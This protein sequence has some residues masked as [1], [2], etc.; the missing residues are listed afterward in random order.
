MTTP[1]NTPGYEAPIGPNDPANMAHTGNE[2][3]AQHPFH[4]GDHHVGH[5]ERP[6]H[7]HE[8]HGHVIVSWQVLTGVLGLLLFFTVLTVATAGI[9][10]W[11]QHAFNTSIPTWLNVALA[12]SIAA[13]KA[14]LVFMFFMQLRYDNPLHTCVLLF[15][16]SGVALFLGLT[17]IDLNNRGHVDRW[18]AGELLAGGT[19]QSLSRPPIISRGD[20]GLQLRDTRLTPKER[21]RDSISGP[22]VADAW[23]RALT[24]EPAEEHGYR[25]RYGQYA[26]YRADLD[27][28]HREARALAYFLTHHES[29]G[30]ELPLPAAVRNRPQEEIQ[31][32][33]AL[34]RNYVH[35]FS[36]DDHAPAHGQH[37]EARHAD[38][39]PDG[40]G[41]RAG[42]TAGLFGNPADDH[43]ADTHAD[44]DH[45]GEH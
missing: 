12:M 40:P 16:L 28:Q 9:E 41:R 44:D 6:G 36:H 8:D 26:F 20:D 10:S 27:P 39:R 24:R 22:I 34:A 32:L 29:H 25:D 15:C 3:D 7:E 5:P 21:G 13:V 14:A 33:L 2:H 38:R 31:Q 45:A 23:Q 17:A 35:E 18:K 42:L 11:V 1:P 4:P 37:A 30:G 19:G 43:H